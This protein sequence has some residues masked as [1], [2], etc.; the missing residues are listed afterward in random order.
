MN[1]LV[2][3]QN[4]QLGQSLAKIAKDYPQFDF[5]FLGREQLDLSQPA[6]L[7]NALENIAFDIII[8]CAAYTAVDKA[9]SEPELAD[10]I[11]HLAVEQLAQ[12]CNQRRAT[13]IHISTD[14]VF[15]GKNYNP[16]IE[17]D[18]VDPQGVYGITKLK[19]EQAMQAVNPKGAIIRTSW[20]YSEFGN[21]FV[22]TM[23]RLGAERDSLNVIYDQVGSPTYATDLA[24]AILA[25]LSQPEQLNQTQVYHYSNEGVCSW[26]DF[27]KAIFEMSGT[28]CKVNPIETKDYPT[29]AKRPHYSLM[30]KAKIKQDYLITIP[31]WRDS[32][33]IALNCLES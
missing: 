15:D 31:Y 2:T 20:V 23:L 10:A 28:R 11:N 17:T 24:Q 1:I 3:G 29:P 30:N 7:A 19:G 33:K 21:N 14:Y 4:G 22:K 27:A 26:Y 25:L 5:I 18:P 8:N 32:L 6:T 16:Y 9:E 13:L 12:I